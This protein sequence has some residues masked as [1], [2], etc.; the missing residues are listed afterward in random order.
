MPEVS[1][2]ITGPDNQIYTISGPEGG[3]REDALRAAPA[4][5]AAGKLRLKETNTP[6]EPKEE[7]SWSQV[8]LEAVKNIPGSAVEFGKSMAQPIMHP[9]DT[10]VAFK[11]LGAGV[12][13]KM[14]VTS[15]HESEQ[16]ADAVGQF[17]K[18]RFGSVEAVKH[19]L[20]HDPVGLAADVSMLLTGGGGLAAR[21]PGI[22]GKIGEAASAA[23]R[24]ADPLNAVG[25][26][27]KGVAQ[28]GAAVARQTAGNYLAH[29]GDR[30][31]GE[32]FQAGKEGGASA[33]AFQ[34]NL[35]G[36]VPAAEV[37]ADA[38]KAVGAIGQEASKAYRSGMIDIAKDKTVLDFRDID[39]EISKTANIGKFK[40]I[41]LETPQ[42][43]A[44]RARMVQ[45]IEDWKNVGWFG[46]AREYHNPE[47]FDALKRSLGH[48]AEE[49][50][51]GSPASKVAWGIYNSVKDTIVQQAPAYAKVMEGYSESK[52]II[53][54][55]ERELAGKPDATVGPALKKLQ[56]VMRNNV[57]TSFGEREKLAELLVENGADHLMQKLAG[58]ALNSWTPRGLGKAVGSGELTV[59]IGA[60]L[61]GH[62][63]VL[64]GI[65]M[66]LP[67]MSPRL[68]GEATYYA[69]KAIDRAGKAASYMPGKGTAKAAFQA[70]RL[71]Q[72][73][74]K[75]RPKPAPNVS[76]AL[77]KPDIPVPGKQSMSDEQPDPV[78]PGAQYAM[79]D[80]KQ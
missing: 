10:A 52:K 34:Q 28:G 47:G 46:D 54:E 75:P 3:T 56:S 50:E 68:L 7:L 57:H 21:A 42:V 16:Y 1:Y 80:T 48:I 67:M 70:G 60:A 71:E 25:G 58:Q 77:E 20:A 43:E 26:M 13:Q 33:E 73:E 18:E 62:P 66:T 27:A 39:A 30:P 69:G 19:T 12:L 40:G 23:G 5:H 6:A 22:V 38:R 61:L 15:G 79:E 49:T 65:L 51:R 29:V 36:Q 41:S 11:N 37:V 78:R 44:T 53:K 35:R 76:D 32:A 2:D 14:G 31:L 24:V 63:K 64:A 72:E 45:K 74:E 4:L 9:V 17:L 59:G 55:V 8:P